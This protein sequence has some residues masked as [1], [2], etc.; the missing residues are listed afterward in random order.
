MSDMKRLSIGGQTYRVRDENAVAYDTPQSLTP[1]QKNR[2]REN[3]GANILIVEVADDCC[4]HTS[5]QIWEHVCSGGGCVLR[6]EDIIY[7][8]QLCTPHYA[9]FAYLTDDNFSCQ[10]I[11]REEGSAEFCELEYASGHL[12]AQKMNRPSTAR[13]GQTVRVSYVNDKGVPINWQAADW[14][15]LDVYFYYNDD[16]GGYISADY[17]AEE[18]VDALRMGTIVQG[19]FADGN[20]D[21][22]FSSLG[23]LMG[24]VHSDS[25]MEELHFRNP[26]TGDILAHVPGNGSYFADGDT[27]NMTAGNE[28][29]RVW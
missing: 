4:T 13:L 24:R 15:A 18:L 17:L 10:W 3:I 5:G 23:Y 14:P 8:L 28:M 12:V 26:V 16:C 27:E 11:V 19:R 6:T 29:W 2:A 7:G 21:L 9:V 20:D 22:E 25:G 1:E